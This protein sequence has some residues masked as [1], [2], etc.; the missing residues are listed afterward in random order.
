MP[1]LRIPIAALLI[2]LAAAAQAQTVLVPSGDSAVTQPG[3][4]EGRAARRNIRE[5]IR[6]GD[7]VGVPPGTRPAA[8]ER[9]LP[10]N[11]A[12]PARGE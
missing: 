6:N 5:A 7:V 12:R 4:T 9:R 3:G 2:A 8:V 1:A 10:R 11:P